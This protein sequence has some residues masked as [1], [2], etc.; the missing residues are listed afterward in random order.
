MSRTRIVFAIIILV[1]L[2][3]I[4]A[5][6]LVQAINNLNDGNVITDSGDTPAATAVPEGTVLVTLASSN[7]KQNWLDQVVDNFN[8]AGK[9]TSSGQAIVV[10]VS[11]VTSGGSLNA[12][13]D[14]TSQPI[15]WSPGDQSWVDQANDAWRQRINKPIASESCQPTIYAPLGF[16][17]W[18]PMA[19]Q[20]GW[21]DTPISW[22]TIVALA[23]DP[24]GWAS[25]GRPEWG[26]FSFGHSHPAYANSGLLAMTSFVYGIAGKT[27]NLT[28]ADIYSD[29][30]QTAMQ[31]L[32]QNTSRYGRQAPA[33]LDLMARQGTSY[34]HAAAAPESDVLRF[35]IERGDELTFPLVFIFPAGGTI[36]A[37]HPYC[38]L[39]NADWVDDDE[40][41]A[42]AIF[43]DYLLARDQ[44]ELAIDNFLRPLDTSIP[45]RAPLSLENGTDPRVSP[46]T[47]P[48]LPSPNADISAAIIDIFTINKRK[49]T[50]LLVI[51]V[52]GSMEGEKIRTA[53]A[54]TAEFLSRLDANDEVGI[55]IFSDIVTL[56]EPPA[57]VGDVVEGLT[58]RVNGLLASGNTALYEAVCQ[59]VET[60]EKTQEDDI[61]TGESRLYGIILLSD[62]EDTVGYVTENQMLATC[63][64]SNAEADGIKIFPIAFGADADEAILQ[65]I[66]DATSGHMFTADPQSISNVYL[67]ISA[68]Q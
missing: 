66:A 2:V 16:A 34:L 43:R 23:S 63:L 49:A 45:L 10:E 60:I 40:A 15:A 47:V 8:A 20:L 52:S 56:M 22:D 6:V 9:T 17:M 61:A 62:G 33:L 26:Q 25:Y 13:L 19:E 35:N 39:D 44:Q 30:V 32:E 48:P 27:D 21:P 5:I 1:T 59:A 50:M 38:I 36:W 57:R 24:E 14:G 12:I 65:R 54:A 29:K 7:T 67:S 18:R 46:A 51:D 55:M 4:G 3:A 53:R 41:E 58:Q 68:E 37:D 11:H 28:P 64:P 42:A 31:E